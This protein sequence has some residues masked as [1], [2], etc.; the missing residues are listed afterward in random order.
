MEVEALVARKTNLGMEFGGQVRW[1]HHSLSPTPPFSM[2]GPLMFF[3]SPLSSSWVPDVWGA[4]ERSL[5]SRAWPG[6]GDSLVG[7]VRQNSQHHGPMKPRP[8]HLAHCLLSC[9]YQV[10]VW[11]QPRGFKQW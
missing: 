5:G 10:P 6:L 11:A 7:E 9:R 2:Q 1:S 4:E 3:S 8:S